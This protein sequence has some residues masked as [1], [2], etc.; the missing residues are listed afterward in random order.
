MRIKKSLIL[1]LISISLTA[2]S[3]KKIELNDVVGRRLFVQKNV[4][5]L[6]SMND[7]LNYTTLENNTKIVKYSYKTGNQVEVLFDLSKIETPGFSTF[8]DYAFSNDETKILFTTNQHSIYRHSFTADYFIW[9]LTTK[10][11]T[12]LSK[13]GTQQLATFSPDG[14]RVAFVRNNNIFIKSL[15]FGT[16]NQVTKDGKTNEGCPSP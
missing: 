2:F 4:T 15:K 14:E 12:P 13:N 8:V 11:M 9:N 16:E 3:Q 1:V 5:G 6:R 10:E 7:G